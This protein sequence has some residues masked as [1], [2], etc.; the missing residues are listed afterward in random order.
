MPDRPT[1]RTCPYWDTDDFDA[2]RPFDWPEGESLERVLASA[3]AQG[4]DVIG[5]CRRFPR[6]W[7][8]RHGDNAEWTD[9]DIW[10]RSSHLDW[11]GEHPNFA[12]YL[13]HWRE[14]RN[15]PKTRPTSEM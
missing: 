2:D 3:M 15:N 14:N 13:V 5:E 1:C 8:G 7:Q 12:A 11:C 10:P 4:V 6:P 9:T